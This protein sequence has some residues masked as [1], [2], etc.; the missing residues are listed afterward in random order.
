VRFLYQKKEKKMKKKTWAAALALLLI[1]SFAFIGCD[2]NPGG[3]G[4]G[5]GTSLITW[6]LT[7]IG[8]AVN[9]EGMPTSDTTAI[10]ITFSAVVN[11]DPEEDIYVE[12]GFGNVEDITG[13]GREYTIEL[14]VQYSELAVIFIFGTRV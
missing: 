3:G 7:Q 14:D 11:L 9:S 10:K 2:D 4:G 8:G 12:G 6:T 13:S 1:G 5:G